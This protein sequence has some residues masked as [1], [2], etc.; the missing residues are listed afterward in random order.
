MDKG[1]KDMTKKKRVI[2]ELVWFFCFV[3]AGIIL[4]LI[5][6]DTINVDIE[7]GVVTAGV[8]VVLLAIYVLRATLWVFKKN[9]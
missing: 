2:K 4:S 8:I 7:P 9:V 5:F 1:A 3:A 6:Y